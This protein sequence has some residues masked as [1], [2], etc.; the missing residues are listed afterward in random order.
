MFFVCSIVLVKTCVMDLLLLQTNQPT[1]TA[2]L[3]TLSTPPSNLVWFP[4]RKEVVVMKFFHGVHGFKPYHRQAS[5]INLS[6][7][8]KSDFLQAVVAYWYRVVVSYVF[9]IFL[10]L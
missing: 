1:M 9:D 10:N 3:Q 8:H 2:I 7:L 6:D 5:S 4:C